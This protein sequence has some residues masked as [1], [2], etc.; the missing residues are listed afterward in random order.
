MSIGPCVSTPPVHGVV[1]FDPAVFAKYYPEFAG[2]PGAALT[3]NFNHATLQLNNS[4]GSLVR[5]AVKRQLLLAMLTAHLTLLNNGTNDGGLSVPAFAGVGSIAATL[6]TVTA[7]TS[8]ALAVGQ[9]VTDLTQT[10]GLGTS[11]TALGTGTGGVGTYTVSVSQTVAQENFLA[12]G[13]PIT[14]PPAGIVGRIA[15]ATEGSVSVAAEYDAPPNASQAWLIQT[16]YGA[17][18]WSA[19]AKYRTAR[20]VPNRN[21]NPTPGLWGPWGG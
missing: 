7:V 11:I 16:K 17:E 20:Y 14:S 13:V 10:I 2:I 12:P 4:C 6:L 8:G 3:R 1:I 21:T 19:T 15:S 18:Y 9:T 5:D